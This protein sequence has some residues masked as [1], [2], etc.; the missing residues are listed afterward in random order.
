MAVRTVVAGV[1][2]E[3]EHADVVLLPRP[4]QGSRHRQ[5]LVDARHRNR[6]SKDVD[7]LRRR[8]LAGRL[9]VCDAARVA[10]EEIS[11]FVVVELGQTGRA[12]RAQQ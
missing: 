10:G 6:L 5:I 8:R 11:H 1:E 7:A 3:A 12:H 2:R 9:A 4:K